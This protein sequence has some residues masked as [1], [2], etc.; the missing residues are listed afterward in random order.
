MGIAAQ[1]ARQR[2]IEAYCSDKGTQ[3]QV[4]DLFVIGLR[5]SVRWWEQ[6][7]YLGQL[8]PIP[9][10]HTLSHLQNALA[11]AAVFQSI[12]SA[13][14]RYD[15]QSIRIAIVLSRTRRAVAIQDVVDQQS[16]T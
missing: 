16:I 12:R 13:E 10:G 6:Y 2:A 5:A 11:S 7:R 1:E 9:R 8:V 4:A 14:Q 3:H 15:Q